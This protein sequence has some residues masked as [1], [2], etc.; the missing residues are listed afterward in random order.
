MKLFSGIALT[1]AA[2]C[3]LAAPAVA[4]DM[5]VT[6]ATVT[7][8]LAGGLAVSAKP[9]HARGPDAIKLV[10]FELNGTAG[11]ISLPPANDS[12]ASGDAVAGDGIWSLDA[13][14]SGAAAGSYEMI[15]YVVDTAGAE[16]VSAPVNVTVR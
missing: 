14:A 13:D 15:V 8:T 16:F 6:D 12:G 7:G 9:L 11:S 4:Q 2:F 1:C 5:T 3:T 10:A